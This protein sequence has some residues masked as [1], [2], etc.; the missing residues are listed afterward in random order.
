MTHLK[1]MGNLPTHDDR[2]PFVKRNINDKLLLKKHH[3]DLL[4]L[5][6]SDYKRI[7]HL[8]FLKKNV[9]FILNRFEMFQEWYSSLKEI[10][11]LLLII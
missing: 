9:N 7:Y 10:I 3:V 4:V 2:E 8:T 1:L 11:L 6:C 5:P